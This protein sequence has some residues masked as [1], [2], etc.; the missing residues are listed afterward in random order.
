MAEAPGSIAP[1]HATAL[2]RAIAPH[3][4]AS[5]LAAM[6]GLEPYGAFTDRT[7]RTMLE[8][9]KEIAISDGRFAIDPEEVAVGV[10]CVAAPILVAGHVM[11]LSVS[12]PRARCSDTRLGE[13]G[14]KVAE[15]ASVISG[16]LAT[17]G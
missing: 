4:D 3:L 17:I 11:G 2:G 14:S 7:P 15:V 6:L 1:M 9:R 16:S 5:R 10:A 13:I 12:I 8:F